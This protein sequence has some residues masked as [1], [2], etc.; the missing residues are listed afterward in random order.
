MTPVSPFCESEIATSCIGVFYCLKWQVHYIFERQPKDLPVSLINTSSR[1][2][3]LPDSHRPLYA[4]SK[5]L[6]LA[7]TK[8]VS[9]QFAQKAGKENRAMGR[10][11]AISPGPIDTPREFAAFG[12]TADDPKQYKAY[13][14]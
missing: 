13:A 4:S 7:S 8:S 14:K 9:N 2:G 1:N 5:A 6:I 10:V 11:N 3:V 12:A